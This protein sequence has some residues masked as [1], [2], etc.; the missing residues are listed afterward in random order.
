MNFLK[1]HWLALCIFVSVA[2][3]VLFFTRSKKISVDGEAAGLVDQLKNN[4]IAS[5]KIHLEKAKESVQEA[6][7]A[8]DKMIENQEQAQKTVLPMEDEEFLEY[9]NRSTK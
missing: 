3:T 4:E 6:Q 9:I 8:A 2:F 7:A 1:K 5:A